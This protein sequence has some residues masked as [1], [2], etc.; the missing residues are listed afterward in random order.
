MAEQSPQPDEGVK[1]PP[2]PDA[3]LKSLNHYQQKLPLWRYKL[4]TMTLPLVRWETPYLAV[5]QEYL[6]TPFLDSWFAITAN[7]GT[8]TFYMVMLPILFWCGYTEFGRGMVHL[9]ATGVCFSG[10]VKDMLCLPRPLSP[11]LQRITMSGSAALE[12]GFPSTHATNAVSVVVYAVYHLFQSDSIDRSTRLLILA[13]LSVYVVSIVMGRLYCGMHGF[14][15]VVMGSLLGAVLGIAQCKYGEAFDNFLFSGSMKEVVIILL[16]ILTFV[17]IHPEPADSCPC[18]DDSVSFAGVMMGAEF[19]N[20]HFAKSTYAWSEPYPATIPFDLQSIGWVRTVLRLILGVLVI[21]VWREVMKPSLHRALPPVFR[22]IER[23]GLS[24]PRRFFTKASE[25]KQVPGHL[26]DDDVFPNMSDIPSMITNIR[27]PRRRAISVGPQSE[28]DAYEALAYREKRRRESL[29]GQRLSP[30][31]ENE[32]SRD[33]SPAM[34]RLRGKENSSSPSRSPLR[35]EEY[36]NMMGSGSP[37]PD[38]ANEVSSDA[39]NSPEVDDE[40]RMFLGITRPRVRYDVEVV[41]KLIVYS[42]IAW[43]SVE[44]NPMLFSYLGLAP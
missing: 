20:W 21:F 26:K 24:L 7:L 15:D 25:Y 14:F 11:P 10:F 22:V 12:Y 8:H 17:R 2:T 41:T 1:T 5:F 33:S 37:V 6:R 32:P 29:S 30:P 40:R 35:L 44:G 38:E 36:E 27:H 39:S 42:G 3:G 4:R 18:F 16:I 13:V 31:V 34:Q 43:W 23:M 19:G 9:L 28:A